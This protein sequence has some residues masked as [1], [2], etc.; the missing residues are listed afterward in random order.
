M[1]GAGDGGGGTCQILDF[2]F[3]GTERRLC[4]WPLLTMPYR[5]GPAPAP[6]PVG[7]AYTTIVNVVVDFDD[8]V[9]DGEC[10]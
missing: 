1:T 9:G 5:S 10:G 8:F 3:R 6:A 7:V 4:P 2:S